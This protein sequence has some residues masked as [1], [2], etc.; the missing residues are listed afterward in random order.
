MRAVFLKAGCCVAVA[1]FFVFSHLA[2]G[3]Q[4]ELAAGQDRWLYKEFSLIGSELDREQGWLPV[5]AL[6]TT[7]ELLPEHSLELT[8]QRS[9]GPLQYRGSTQNGQTLATGTQETEFELSAVWQWQLLDHWSLDAGLSQWR[10]FRDIQATAITQALSERYDSYGPLL[11]LRY[12]R[13]LANVHV[14]VSAHY[15][16]WTGANMRMDLRA[17]GYGYVDI[18]MPDGRAFKAVI[19]LTKPLSRQWDMGFEYQLSWRTFPWSDD[20]AASNGFRTIY[21]AEPESEDFRHGYRLLFR[22]HW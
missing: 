11:G 13:G 9:A 1:G 20:V 21:L 6:A 16:Y 5:L 15:Q 14:E 8:F 10:W 22:R 19:Q 17:Q 18:P 7:H 3:L 4:L 2:N 12:Q